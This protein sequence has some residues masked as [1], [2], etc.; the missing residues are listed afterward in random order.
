ML[1]FRAELTVDVGAIREDAENFYNQTRDHFGGA[2][3]V[4]SYL[5]EPAGPWNRESVA[6]SNVAAGP[7]LALAAVIGLLT[8]VFVKAE[9][10]RGWWFTLPVL[11]AIAVILPLTLLMPELRRSGHIDGGSSAWTA[12]RRGEAGRGGTGNVDDHKEQSSMIR[13]FVIRRNRDA[14]DPRLRDVVDGAHVA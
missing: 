10:L 6:P 8:R 3:R 14:D 9:W 5:A 4:E 7:A 2:L 11:P 13:G 1:D 12:R